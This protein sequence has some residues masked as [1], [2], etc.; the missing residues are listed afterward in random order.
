M[1]ET[2]EFE[3]YAFSQEVRRQAAMH[4]VWLIGTDEEIWSDVVV[5]AQRL[6]QKVAQVSDRIKVDLDPESYR[7][8]PVDIGQMLSNQNPLTHGLFSTQ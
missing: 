5:L 8:T 7:L 6:Y 2:E 1:S 4:N 3:R